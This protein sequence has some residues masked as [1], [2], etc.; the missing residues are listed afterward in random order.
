MVGHLDSTTLESHKT[1][2]PLHLPGEHQLGHDRFDGHALFEHDLDERLAD[3]PQDRSESLLD[4]Q[5]EYGFLLGSEFNGSL[6]QP[7]DGLGHGE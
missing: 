6:A 4:G 3:P 1:V 7:S 2:C 5:V